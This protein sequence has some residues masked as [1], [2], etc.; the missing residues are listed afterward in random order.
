MALNSLQDNY[1]SLNPRDISRGRLRRRDAV[2]TRLA[3]GLRY[4]ALHFAD[5][6]GNS[7]R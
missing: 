4:V 3:G 5:A 1:W 7:N 6:F 2:L